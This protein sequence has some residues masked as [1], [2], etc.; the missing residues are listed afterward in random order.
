MNIT[1]RSITPP[2]P[3]INTNIIKDLHLYLNDGEFSIY[4]EFGDL[5]CPPAPP[6]YY[7]E[8]RK[9]SCNYTIQIV[10]KTAP[11]KKCGYCETQ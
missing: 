7:K 8:V 9:C 1:M 5:N 4:N 6:S 10:L 3:K 2:R 11:L